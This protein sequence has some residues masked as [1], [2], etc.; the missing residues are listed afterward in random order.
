MQLFEQHAAAALQFAVHTFWI[1]T[2]YWRGL[3]TGGSEDLTPN[4]YGESS[5]FLG[6][7]SFS[8]SNS[9]ASKN[10]PAPSRSQQYNFLRTNTTTF[11]F[12]LIH[13]SK[14]WSVSEE[15]ELALAHAETR[16]L[17]QMCGEHQIDR[18]S[19]VLVRDRLGCEED[20]SSM[21]RQN[22]S[23]W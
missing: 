3:N 12:H 11:S 16:M 8:I 22:R 1:C 10:S 13:G 4:T 23:R 2:R 20:I 6:F 18:H 21:L 15:N 14:T 19:N 7:V 17:R 5:I 9:H